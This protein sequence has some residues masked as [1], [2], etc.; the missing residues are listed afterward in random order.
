MLTEIEIGKALEDLCNLLFV[1]AV[2]ESKDELH[3]I[4]LLCQIVFA[5]QLW[6]LKEGLHCLLIS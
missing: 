6:T 5:D 2:I 4:D 3:L 1:D